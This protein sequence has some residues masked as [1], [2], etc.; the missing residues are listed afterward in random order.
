MKIKKNSDL[1]L[2]IEN[3]CEMLYNCDIELDKAPY[4]TTDEIVDAINA[5]LEEN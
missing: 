3:V 2:A 4:K 5:Y 1:Y